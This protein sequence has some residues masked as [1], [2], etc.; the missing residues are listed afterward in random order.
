MRPE[1][2][3]KR[4]AGKKAANPMTDGRAVGA[5]VGGVFLRIHELHVERMLDALH[6][7]AFCE[8]HGFMALG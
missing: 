5:S 8:D 1:E 6:E 2:E 7:G 4:E 3:E